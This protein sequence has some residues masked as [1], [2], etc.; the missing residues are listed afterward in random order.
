MLTNYF[1]P[2]FKDRSVDSLAKADLLRFRT[3]LGK[4]TY[5]NTQKT[6][7]ASRINQIMILTRMIVDE[8]AERYGFE[9]PYKGIKQ[10]KE[11]K[12]DIHPFTLEEMWL[13]LGNVRADYKNYYLVRFFSGLRTSEI[14][15]LSWDNVDFARKEIR[16]REALVNGKVGPT[17]TQGSNRDVEM[18]QLVFD[19]LKAQEAITKGK[20][21]YVFCNQQGKPLSYRNVNRRIWHPTLQ[22]LNIPARKAYQTRH[23]CATLWL[24]SGENPEWV[25]KQLGHSNTEMLFRI[26]SRYVPNLTRRDGSAF[27]A[28]VKQSQMSHSNIE[29]EQADAMV[30]EA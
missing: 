1:L 27:D 4:V 17:K 10:L 22:L 21:R 15:G 3:S 11:A 26:Y 24:A 5:G 8:A 9:T 13:F 20:S 25:A 18:A 23:T 6:L 29:V 2:Q 7:S 28:M 30:G 14:D 19:S 12:V 16:V